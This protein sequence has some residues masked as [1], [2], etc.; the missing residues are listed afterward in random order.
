EH[1]GLGPLLEASVGTTLGADPRGVQR[2]PLAAG[3]QHKENGV[4]GAAVVHARVMATERGGLSQ[5]DQRLHL[6]PEFVREAP[7]IIVHDQ[8]HG[9]ASFPGVLTPGM[10]PSPFL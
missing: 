9:S 5:G 7:T 1:P 4:H 2:F 8:S 10:Y 6:G 3:A